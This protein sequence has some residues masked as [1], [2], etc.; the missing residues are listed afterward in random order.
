VGPDPD[1]IDDLLCQVLRQVFAQE[2]NHHFVT[3]DDDVRDPLGADDPIERFD[4][5]LDVV[6]VEVADVP[7][8]S[9][10]RPAS[11]R[12]GPR[13][14]AVHDLGVD[15]LVGREDEDSRGVGVD[16]QRRVPRV[17]GLDACQ[18]VEVRLVADVE[19]VPVDRGIQLQRLEQLAGRAGE[20]C[21]A[22][23]GWL[24]FGVQ[25]PRDPFEISVKAL[26]FWRAGWIG[27]ATRLQFLPDECLVLIPAVL[28]GLGIEIQTY[29]WVWC[30][31]E[32]RQSRELISQCHTPPSQ[33]AIAR[34]EP[35][36][37]R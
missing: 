2:R 6:Q 5:V 19:K 7:L 9:R 18:G 37:K 24:Q 33:R 16:E 3:C 1:V 26:P 17:P 32:R 20:D 23:A 14:D 36:L 10:L 11:L 4:D 21:Q 12:R 15:Q 8:V 13:L 29:D 31:F 30:R 22:V 34:Q 27:P 35:A 28:A 25:V